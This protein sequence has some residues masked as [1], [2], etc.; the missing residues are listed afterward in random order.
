MC[1]LSVFNI[2]ANITEI[3]IKTQI[4]KEKKTV[5]L[6]FEFSSPPKRQHLM[7]FL[8]ISYLYVTEKPNRPW[9]E[10]GGSSC[11]SWVKGVP[12]ELSRLIGSSQSWGTPSDFFCLPAPLSWHVASILKVTSWGSCWKPQ[13]SHPHCKWEERR[14]RR[15]VKHSRPLPLQGPPKVP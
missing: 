8:E 11:L 1:L 10:H 2:T 14:E 9:F 13:P 3:R 15:A 4:I 12:R 7:Y 5:T 6:R